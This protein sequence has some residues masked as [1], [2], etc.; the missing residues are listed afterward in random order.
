[1]HPHVIQMVLKAPSELGVISL[2][3]QQA[4]LTLICETDT[5]QLYSDSPNL[6]FGSAENRYK[7][8]GV[9]DLDSIVKVCLRLLKV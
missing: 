2:L 6:F 3:L 7:M 1:M 4:G 8:S 9:S 5:T